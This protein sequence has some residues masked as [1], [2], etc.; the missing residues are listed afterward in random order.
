M[1]EDVK[2]LVDRYSS[3]DEPVP[4]KG[5]LI[6]PILVKQYY[7]FSVSYDVLCIEKN[8]IPDVKVIQMNY[9]DFLCERLMSDTTEIKDGYTVGNYYIEKL[10][11]VL[12]VCFRLDQRQINIIRDDKHW[13]LVIN[14]V[15]INSQEF[16]DIRRIIMYQ[17]I[18][19]Y[20]DEYIDPDFKKAVDEFYEI[21]NR[22]LKNPDLELKISAIT[23]MSGITKKDILLMTYRELENV[24]HSCLDK[25]EY[26][27]MHTAELSGNV[28]FDKPIDHWVYK[29]KK[30]RY[31]DAFVSAD[32]VKDKISS[33]NG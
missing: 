17:N 15:T 33:V 26:Q 30:N 22:G 11:L 21:K 12:C 25:M 32:A 10:Y 23:A 9:L 13:N 27:M 7:D 19:D 3:I 8:K 14:G 29:R 5:L 1:I 20:F 18:Y 24:F 31:E 28:K 4:Y 2:S 16:D 6:Y